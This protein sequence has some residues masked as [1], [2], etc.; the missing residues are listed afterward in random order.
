MSTK[1][2]A[3]P[4]AAAPVVAS[5]SPARSLVLQRK[6]ACGGSA[7]SSGECTDCNKLPIQRRAAS[8]GLIGNVPPIV[9]NVLSSAG[10]PLDTGT[11]SVMESRIGQDLGG[12]RGHN[13]FPAAES[14]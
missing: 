5:F 1:A 8:H 9:H 12:G 10:P 3:E 6:C 11:R 4:K 7:G 2:V 13:G 14:A